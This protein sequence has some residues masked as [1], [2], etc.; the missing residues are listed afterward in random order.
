MNRKVVITGVFIVAIIGVIG[1]FFL[2]PMDFNIGRKIN[3]LESNDGIREEK[4][5]INGKKLMMED[6]HE[7]KET[8][9]DGNFVAYDNGVVYDTRTGFEWYAGPDKNTN[10]KKAK[11]WVE[12]LDAAGGGWRMPTCDELRTLFRKGAGSKD[13]SP[14]S[15]NITPLFKARGQFIWSAQIGEIKG[16][17][18][19][20]WDA[21]YFNFNFDGFNDSDLFWFSS[22]FRSFAVRT[23]QPQTL[24]AAAYQGNITLVKD[25]LDT[26]ADV[27]AKDGEGHT[28]LMMA[29]KDGP[30]GQKK[31]AELE[32][33]VQLLV[34]KGADVNAK[35]KNG[36]TAL[37]YAKI[38]GMVHIKKILKQ[39]GAEE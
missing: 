1:T 36:H 7:A 19:S 25:F 38:R 33:I 8:K 21:E 27:N 15:R 18:W 17:I 39:H 14:L 31:Y 35:Q 9:R 20:R 11:S 6:K 32:K 2:K 28:A 10:W 29:I 4:H 16:S 12:N 30:H 3:L 23:R 34:D 24:L 37:Y 22:D 13:I 5:S 26:G